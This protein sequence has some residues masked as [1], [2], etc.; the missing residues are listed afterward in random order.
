[1]LDKLERFTTKLEFTYLG[2]PFEV[3]QWA[4][5]MRTAGVKVSSIR[6]S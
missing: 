3:E 2:A 5:I 1:M 6:T 4:G